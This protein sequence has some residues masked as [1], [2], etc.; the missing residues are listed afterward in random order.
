MDLLTFSMVNHKAT[1]PRDCIKIIDFEQKN[2]QN[3][4]A[5]QHPCEAKHQ[6]C[7]KPMK[8][9]KPTP[10]TIREVMAF[11]ITLHTNKIKIENIKAREIFSVLYKLGFTL[12]SPAQMLWVQFNA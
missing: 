6:I 10:Q 2:Q 4:S 5:D 9:H 11:A 3:F 7:I 1:L 12:F 8:K